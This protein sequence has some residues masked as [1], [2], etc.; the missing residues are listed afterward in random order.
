MQKAEVH[1]LPL[2][3]A[4]VGGGLMLLEN[5]IAASKLG[6]IEL[7]HDLYDGWD[8]TI[9]VAGSGEMFVNRGLW[10]LG[11]SILRGDRNAEAERRAKAEASAIPKRRKT[12]EA[13]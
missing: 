10:D 6:P 2:A 11:R 13:A 12:T 4:P 9:Y 7:F 5:V 8:P 1:F 3:S